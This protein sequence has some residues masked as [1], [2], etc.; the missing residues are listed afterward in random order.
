MPLGV[1][2][3]TAVAVAPA[4]TAT[5]PAQ[6]A[7]GT[8]TSNA[9]QPHSPGANPAIAPPGSTGTANAL[10]LPFKGLAVVDL[11]RNRRY[12]SASGKHYLVFQTD[13]NL[14]IR[15]AQEGFVW[16]LNEVAPS[17]GKTTKVL[18]VGD[19]NLMA[20]AADNSTVWKALSQHRPVLEN[21]QRRYGNLELND[22]GVL[23]IISPIDGKVLWGTR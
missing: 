18:F 1:A 7:A 20:V 17:F 10:A 12:F 2:T 19:G 15:T 5:V 16:G 23:Q 8:G 13:G 6:A 3:A 4:T 22:Q 9:A 11:E 21:G 14:V